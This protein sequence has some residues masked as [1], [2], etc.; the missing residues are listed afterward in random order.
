[1]KLTS[2]QRQAMVGKSF[3]S[4]INLPAAFVTVHDVTQTGG[5][6]T[7]KFTI[8]CDFHIRYLALCKFL[9]RYPHELMEVGE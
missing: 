8:P 7:V 1:M 4:D 2:E 5:G 3:Y 9:K 6:H